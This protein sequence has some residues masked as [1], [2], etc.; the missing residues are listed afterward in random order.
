M[1]KDDKDENLFGP[2]HTYEEICTL[3]PGTK[4]RAIPDTIPA[5]WP[6]GVEVDR[7]KG[8][9]IFWLP[10][11]WG[12]G[13]KQTSG[14]KTLKTYISPEGKG[15][16]HKCEIEKLLGYELASKEKGQSGPN[17]KLDPSLLQQAVP[18]WPEDDW[19][20]KDFRIGYR[21]L[22]KNLHRI[23]VPPNQEEGFLYHR[24]DVEAYLEGKKGVSPFG[25]SRWMAEIS[26]EAQTNR[27]DKKDSTETPAV[28]RRKKDAPSLTSSCCA[29]AQTGWALCSTLEDA[30]KGIVE[31]LSLLSQRGF[32]QAGLV[33]VHGV[34][35]RHQHAR[36]IRGVYLRG[37][38][39]LD[40]KP[41][42]QKLVNAPAS[43][44]SFGCDGVYIRWIERLQQW[45]ICSGLEDDEVARFAFCEKPHAQLLECQHGWQVA[46]D[47]KGIDAFAPEPLLLNGGGSEAIVGAVAG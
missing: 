22:P 12:Q 40:G 46:S 44:Q 21:R 8:G 1:S 6:P 2:L 45:S 24:K 7:G 19:L 5:H 29:V 14:G 28:K 27:E 16:Y 36:C 20:P 42:Y 37:P 25:T 34:P 30:Q 31:F 41:F 11:D 43:T 33:A 13:I 10:D 4:P 9:W 35:D 3:K 39:L 18:S 26:A 38:E 23:Y 15:Y 17:G 47:P 32:T